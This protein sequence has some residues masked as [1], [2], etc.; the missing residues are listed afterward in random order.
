MEE[1]LKAL[2]TVKGQI[3]EKFEEIA[4]K[5][6]EKL[7][8]TLDEAEPQIGKSGTKTDYTKQQKKAE[9]PEDNGNA[10]TVQISN[11]VS[12]KIR[13]VDLPNDLVADSKGVYGYLPTPDS[14]F[15]SSKWPVDWTN[16]D[17]VSAARTTRLEYHAGLE[18][19]QEFIN[20]LRMEGVSDD[21]IAEQIAL[22]MTKNCS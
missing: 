7:G 20:N 3:N 9:S 21:S 5:L 16:V 10:T 15:H 4:Q 11:T 14:Q 1:T 6:S 19:K 17:Q 2:Q 22:Y 18:K 12:N 8:K 13:Y